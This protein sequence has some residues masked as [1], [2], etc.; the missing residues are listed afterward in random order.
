MNTM[1]NREDCMNTL[2][3]RVCV[4]TFTKRD[5]T[6]RVMRCT[7]KPE[8]LPVATTKPQV[9]EE[10]TARKVNPNTVSVWDLDK[11]AWRG[12]ALDSI[13]DMKQES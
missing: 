7:L 11:N 4:V 1:M 9:R 8:Y 12:F 5:G 2:R 13:K 3:S 10:K 6:E